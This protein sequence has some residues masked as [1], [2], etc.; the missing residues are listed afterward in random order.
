MRI[1]SVKHGNDHDNLHGGHTL[2]S[3]MTCLMRV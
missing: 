3:D 1:S 2:M